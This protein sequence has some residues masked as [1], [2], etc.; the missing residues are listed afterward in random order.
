MNFKFK[1]TDQ[2]M[3]SNT[4]GVRLPQRDELRFESQLKDAP[5]FSIRHTS[6]RKVENNST[7]IFFE[8]KYIN[9]S[10]NIK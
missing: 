10:L 4:K 8:R 1:I 6:N 7:Y 9:I 2:R 3:L 5:T